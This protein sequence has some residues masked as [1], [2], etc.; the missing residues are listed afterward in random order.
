MI[1]DSVSEIYRGGAEDL[2]NRLLI[3]QVSELIQLAGIMTKYACAYS[4]I[5][6][7]A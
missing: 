7:V 5:P 4:V 3:I 2:T 1:S 6:G